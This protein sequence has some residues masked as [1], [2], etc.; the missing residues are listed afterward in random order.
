M[1]TAQAGSRCI[2]CV[3]VSIHTGDKTQS[4]SRNWTNARS[5]RCWRSL[6][7]PSLRAR[8][9]ENGRAGSSR[10]TGTPHASAIAT[11]SSV[12]PEST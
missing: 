6:P 1:A 7:K 2:A 12:D 4:P 3:A 5:G 11:L 9:A 8:A 10:W